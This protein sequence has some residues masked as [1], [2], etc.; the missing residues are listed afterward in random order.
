MLGREID[1]P[2]DLFSSINVDFFDVVFS[3][4]CGTKFFSAKGR[5]E[6]WEAV[7]DGE[8]I[9]RKVA[10]GFMTSKKVVFFVVSVFQRS[11]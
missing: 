7:L 5:L 8:E 3:R 6:L 1:C 4:M 2:D 9:E 11:K 10:P